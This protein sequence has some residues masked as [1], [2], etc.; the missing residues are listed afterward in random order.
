MNRWPVTAEVLALAAE[1]RMADARR[2]AR[3]G[4]DDD[5]VWFSALE[6]FV[7][8]LGTDF[9][10][11]VALA[12]RALGGVGDDV[13]HLVAL[14]ARGLAAAGWWPAPHETWTDVAP[15]TTSTGDPL[16][17]AADLVG[18]IAGDATPVAEFARYLVAEAALAC[19]R[20]DLAGRVVTQSGPPPEWT[21]PDGSRH[22]YAE[23]VIVMRVRLAAFRGLI[24]H[25][26]ALLVGLESRTHDALLSLLIASTASVVRGNAADR[27]AAR[28]LADRVESSDLPAADYLS[29][30]CRLL[31]AFGLVAVG[32]IARSAR[33]LL[34]AGGDAGLRSLAI[35]DRGLGLELLVAVAAASDDLD[36]AEAWVVQ[37]GDLRGHPIAGSTVAR[38]DSRV[39]L[40]AG[41]VTAAVAFADLAIARAQDEGRAIEAAEGEIVAT[42]AR[43]AAAE[44]GIAAARLEAAVADAERTGYRA[45]RVSAA[46]ELR[47]SGRRLRPLA[48][49][50]WEGLSVRERDVALLIAQGA[51]N[52]GVARALH[53]SD[54]TV[55]AHVGRVLAAFGAASRLAVAEQLADRVPAEGTDVSLTPRQRAVADSVARGLGNS[56]IAAELGI[57]A[58]TVEKHLADIRSRWRVSTRGELAR[59]ARGPRE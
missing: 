57:S 6:S 45:L 56:A 32:D 7:A 37:A 2:R 54:H 36:A 20:L 12:D 34:I 4:T 23:I 55:R 25:A 10:D 24:D 29:R 21:L 40:L 19:G 13:A 53:L 35:I 50:G 49:T 9:E 58:K 31:A 46:R 5:E 30:G 33:M 14:A 59:L 27:R 41:D 43:V 47:P 3:A 51:S 18:G 39:A 17:E 15:H 44:A 1:G 16:R 26:E 48:G 8:F 22:P 11:A 42:R 52:A 38:I 28:A